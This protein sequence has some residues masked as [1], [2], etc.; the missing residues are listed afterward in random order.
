MRMKSTS[1]QRS[2]NI[3]HPRV[4]EYFPPPHAALVDCGT[5]FVAA[6][7]SSF[8]LLLQPIGVSADV[9]GDCVVQD[10]VQDCRGNDAIAEH[11]APGT[12]ALIAGARPKE[13][14]EP[15]AADFDGTSGWS[16]KTRALQLTL[17]SAMAQYLPYRRLKCMLVANVGFSAATGVFGQV[18]D[19]CGEDSANRL[20]NCGRADLIFQ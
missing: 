16:S 4:I 19:G 7:Q 14:A 11:L 5:L 17:N 3:P 20:R 9:E 2:S 15:T 13:L 1:C 6:D 8:K 12:K 10:A 18:G